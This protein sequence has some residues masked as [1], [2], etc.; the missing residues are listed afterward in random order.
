MRVSKGRQRQGR[1]PTTGRGLPRPIETHRSAML[2]RV[3]WY[4][5]IFS[6]FALRSLFFFF[7][8]SAPSEARKTGEGRGD[9]STFAPDALMTGA[10]RFSFSA[11]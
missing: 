1:W 9:H 5:F 11:R 6:E 3:R 4:G 8:V 2:L 10:S 7:P